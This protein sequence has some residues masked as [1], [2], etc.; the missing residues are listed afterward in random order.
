MTKP[1]FS[2][3]EQLSAYLD[4]KLSQADSARLAT[5]LQMDPGLRAVM[6][7]LSQSRGLLRK[8]PARRA[9]RNFTLTPKLAGVKP[10]L[11]RAYPALRW[12]T[13]FA[14]IL[15][16]FTFAA[17]LLSPVLGPAFGIGLGRG[18]GGPQAAS[19][20]C[21]ACGGGPAATEVPATE[22]P[23]AAPAPMLAAPTL[24]VTS[25][26][27]ASQKNI[28]P[29][30]T[31]IVEQPVAMPAALSGLVIPLSWQIGLLMI[32][33]ACGAMAWILR[34]ASDSSWRGKSK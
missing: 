11:P 2:D 14:T 23:A 5:R 27:D 24:E 21:Q 19:Q 26:P 7:D 1:S 16:F 33:L 30:P 31:D 18:G 8:L 4:G 32:A 34:L 17:N 20:L 15:L 6:D 12:T 28:N 13:S 9:P 29:E 25:V 3:V 10:P 22:A